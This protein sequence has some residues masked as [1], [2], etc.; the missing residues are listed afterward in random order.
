METL[1]II[2]YKQP[3]IRAEVEAIRGVN[4]DSLIGQLIAK[5]LVTIAGR[6]DTVGRPHYLKTT[7]QFLDYFGLK[8]LD[9]LPSIEEIEKMLKDRANENQINLFSEEEMAKQPISY[10]PEHAAVEEDEHLHIEAGTD[11]DDTTE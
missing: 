8:S 10:S 6:A 4:S 2:T 1:A 9:D 5:N 11:D 7:K 3:I